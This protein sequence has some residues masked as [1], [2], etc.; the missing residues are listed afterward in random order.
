[1]TQPVISFSLDGHVPLTEAMTSNLM[2]VNKTNIHNLLVGLVRDKKASNYPSR[3]VCSSGLYGE[4]VSCLCKELFSGKMD[5]KKLGLYRRSLEFRTWRESNNVTFTGNN[6]YETIEVPALIFSQTIEMKR[7]YNLKENKTDYDRDYVNSHYQTSDLPAIYL[8]IEEAWKKV[9]TFSSNE[10]NNQ[11]MRRLIFE[12]FVQRVIDLTGFFT[13]KKNTDK[14]N[15]VN[16]AI[17]KS[18]QSYHS[19]VTTNERGVPNTRL[20]YYDQFG[21]N[22]IITAASYE[23]TLKKNEL[24][25]A[26]G[27]NRRSA[28][29]LQLFPCKKRKQEHAFEMETCC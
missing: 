21:S 6:K 1:M 22:V 7:T 15:Y 13:T 25:A 8:Q 23:T 24:S 29:L 17:V 12:V 19:Y 11:L 18:I 10:A 4:R 27:I 3:K 26:L 14:E 28:F 5:P 20:S 16:A 9:V 2:E